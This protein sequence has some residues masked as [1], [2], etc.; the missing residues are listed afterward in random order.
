MIINIPPAPFK[1]GDVT[2]NIHE[3]LLILNYPLRILHQLADFLQRGRY[4]G[5]YT[6]K[7][8]DFKLSSSHTV[9]ARRL[10]SKIINYCH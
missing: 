2:V 7:T 1:G 5:Q 4:D 9:S 3:K 8:F 10:P 6:R